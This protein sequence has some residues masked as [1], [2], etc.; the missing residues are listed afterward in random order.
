M[1]DQTLEVECDLLMN[2][3]TLLT[4]RYNLEDKLLAVEIP[5]WSSMIDSMLKCVRDMAENKEFESYKVL[6][7]HARVDIIVDE[8][9]E[10]FPED[11]ENE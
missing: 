4:L 7:M 2:N 5:F 10:L 1:D 9:D 6:H 8:H 11:D 3:N